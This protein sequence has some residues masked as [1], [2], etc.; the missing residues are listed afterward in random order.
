MY[1]KLEIPLN[2]IN[3]RF[4]ILNE[5]MVSVMSMA[6]EYGIKSLLESCGTVL[7]KSLSPDNVFYYLDVSKTFSCHTLLVSFFIDVQNFNNL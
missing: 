4:K 2:N 1:S 6:V 7:G 5:Q 3:L